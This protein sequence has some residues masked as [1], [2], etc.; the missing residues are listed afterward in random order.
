MSKPLAL[1]RFD[2]FEAVIGTVHNITW[3]SGWWV[4][5]IIGGTKSF[6]FYQVMSLFYLLWQPS[7]YC[8]F[9]VPVF[10]TYWGGCLITNNYYFI[11][12][13]MVYFM[14]PFGR[15]ILNW[16]ITLISSMP[17]R[18]WGPKV[19]MRWSIFACVKNSGPMGGNFYGEQQPLEHLNRW[20][21]FLAS[22]LF[23]EGW[24]FSCVLLLRRYLTTFLVN[25]IWCWARIEVLS[26]FR[27]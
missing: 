15:A 22:R 19:L 7:F 10:L 4:I 12:G 1:S 8:K 18:S 2:I 13:G 17:I 21:V 20:A 11:F 25:L 6:H 23:K 3:S 5:S 26:T 24:I 14:F 16:V 27:K 9:F